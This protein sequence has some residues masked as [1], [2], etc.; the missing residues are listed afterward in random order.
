MFDVIIIGTGKIGID[1]YI[2]LK[3]KEFLIKYIFLIQIKTLKVLNT[4]EKIIF[5]TMIRESKV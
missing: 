1:L 3:K 5:Y 4:V 2:K